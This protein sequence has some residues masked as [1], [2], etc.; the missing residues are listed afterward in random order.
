MEIKSNFYK[1]FL[2]TRVGDIPSPA[3]E[4]LIDEFAINAKFYMSSPED[5]AT[6]EKINKAVIEELKN[7]FRFLPLHLVGEAY[8][9]GAKGEL[10]GTTRFTFRNVYT[11]LK[12]IEEK[13]QRL[14]IEEISRRDQQLRHE[15]EK[16][17]K[18][19]QR[20]NSL[21]G[22]AFYW[23]VSQCPMPDKL[24]D[25][26]TLDKIVESLENGYDIRTLKPE[27]VL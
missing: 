9:R 22:T 12:Q 21:Y 14:F 23:K 20:R 11:W 24:Y 26:L 1:S 3:L 6:T 13:N 7:R 2:S 19:F 16:H 18:T 27:D 10:G 5:A 15:E 4:E 25:A 8:D 17:Y